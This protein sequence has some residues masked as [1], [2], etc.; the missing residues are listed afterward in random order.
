MLFARAARSFPDTTTSHPFAPLSHDESK[1]AI[2][3]SPDSQTIEKLV[4]QRF[5]L[6]D[7]GKTT[8]LNLGS[9]KRDRIFGKFKALLDERGKFANATA[10]L[11]QNF[12]CMCSANN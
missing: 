6:G 2:A 7:G 5:A 9:V 11:S 4:A 8:V 3:R 1:D 10:L 12:L